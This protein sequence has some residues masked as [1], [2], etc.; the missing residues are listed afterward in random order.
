MFAQQQLGR[1]FP[2]LFR[3]RKND[4]REQTRKYYHDSLLLCVPAP[5]ERGCV[6]RL[7]REIMIEVISTELTQRCLTRHR[8]WAKTGASRREARRR[9]A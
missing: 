6:S 1:L 3:M 5:D 4:Q 9:A 2:V 7:D 8:S